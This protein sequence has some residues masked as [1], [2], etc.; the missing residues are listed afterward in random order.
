MTETIAWLINLVLHLDQKL[1]DLSASLG[2]WLYV[3]LFSVVFCE[4]GLIITPM[5]PGDSLLF[6]VGALVAK[7]NSQLNL[8]LMFVL[9][10][11][12]A[13]LGDAVNYAIGR[14]LGPRVF[15]SDKSRLLNKRHLLKA[16]AFYDRHGGKAIFLARFIPIVRTF[17]PF[18]AG[19]GRM[20]RFRFWMFN[21]T[22]GVCWVGLFLFG[23]YLFG[24]FRI[25]KD[26]YPLVIIGIIVVSALP[27]IYEWYRTRRAV[28]SEGPDVSSEVRT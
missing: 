8:G 18:V 14:T 11:I 12:A 1:V 22:G 6:A 26:N 24:N 15:H 10:T 27:V 13:I 5:L 4:T 17:A 23:G 20:N 16:Q 9:M 3:I 28:P 19:V 21:A 2:N 25:V 7:E